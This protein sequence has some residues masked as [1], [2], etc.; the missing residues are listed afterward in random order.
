MSMP[1]YVL[2]FKSGN[3]SKWRYNPPQDAID[4]GVV[5]RIE[6][7]NTY[8]TAYALAEEQNKILD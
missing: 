3:K 7:G 6:L 2:R 8:Q 4:A 5:K 1:R